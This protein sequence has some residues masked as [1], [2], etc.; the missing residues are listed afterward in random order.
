MRIG[1]DSGPAVAGSIGSEHHLKY[2]AVGEV[3]L[4]AQRL[5]STTA[6]A[7]D[8]EAEP[9][10][11]LISERTLELLGEG[12]ATEAVGQVSLKGFDAGVPV[13]RVL[14]AREPL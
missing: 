6:V 9:C 4:T 1:I 10:R 5:E 13:Y 3:V 14:S 12:Y 11:I 7:H 2:S 8:F